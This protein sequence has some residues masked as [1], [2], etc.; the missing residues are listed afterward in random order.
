MQNG[1]TWV[2]FIPTDIS[3]SGLTKVLGDEPRSSSSSFK[4]YSIVPSVDLFRCQNVAER[5]LTS[6]SRSSESESI[7]TSI[8]LFLSSSFGGSSSKILFLG[9]G[10]VPTGQNMNLLEPTLCFIPPLLGF[11]IVSFF[12]FRRQSRCNSFISASTTALPDLCKPQSVV[13]RYLRSRDTR[14]HPI[15]MSRQRTH[16][17]VFSAGM[18]V[19]PFRIQESQRFKQLKWRSMITKTTLLDVCC[20]PTI[21]SRC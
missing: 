1:R 16:R 7:T 3:T 15:A 4:T 8:T 9:G 20:S 2:L 5:R 21:P 11:G 6:I 19:A 18:H 10:V 14:L 12:R 17:A 13:A